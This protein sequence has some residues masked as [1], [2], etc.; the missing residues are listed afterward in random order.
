MTARWWD[1][2]ALAD[3]LPALRLR[4]RARS[5][6]RDWFDARDFDE[7]ETPALQVSPG[8]EP[9]LAA[10]ETRLLPPGGYGG[11]YGGG[12][13]GRRLFL[14]TSPEFAMKKLLA[15]GMERIWQLCPVYRNAEGSALHSPEFAMLEWYRVGE[16]YTALMDDCA[17]MIG[18]IAEARGVETF[19]RGDRRSDPTAPFARMSVAEAFDTY[20]GHDLAATV[21]ECPSDPPAAPLIETARRMGIHV[22]EDDRFDDV[23]FRLMDARIE[24]HLGDGAPCLLY[25]YPISMAA[26]ARPKVGDPLWAERVELYVCGVELA[27]GFS[28]LTDGAEQRRRF[29]ADMDLKES[30]YGMRY[31]ID[32]D[33]L[34]A[35]DAMPEAAGMALGFDRLVMLLAGAPSIGSVSWASVE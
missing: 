13:A 3:R 14:H 35:V 20:C 31:P 8:M 1:R 9:H 7:V 18:H 12:D 25:D 28:E 30:L 23:F 27:N 24:P 6:L 29:E 21:R 32:E 2:R 5:A 11:G 15:G 22:A 26:L 10:F 33:F 19:R 34:A 16:D 17:S 4:N